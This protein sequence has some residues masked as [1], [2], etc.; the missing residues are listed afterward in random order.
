ML[1]DISV[2]ESE[3]GL[4]TLWTDWSPI[5]G[6]LYCCVLVSIFVSIFR[7]IDYSSINGCHEMSKRLFHGCLN[8]YPNI[9]DEVLLLVMT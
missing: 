9:L 2:T 6:T 1:L 3:M 8:L 7:R 5:R 4:E